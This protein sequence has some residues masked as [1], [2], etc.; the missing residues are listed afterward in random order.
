MVTNQLYALSNAEDFNPYDLD[1][2]F[3]D[4]GLRATR[5]HPNYLINVVTW[6][7]RDG[8]II[9]RSEID[10]TSIRLTRFKDGLV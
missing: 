3:S 10:E 1:T 6:I 7:H 9:S 8:T 5:A 4:F 2:W